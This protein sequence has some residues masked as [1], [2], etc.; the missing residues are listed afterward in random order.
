MRLLLGQRRLL[1]LPRGERLTALLE[2]SR[3]YQNEVSERLAEQVLHALY[4]LLRG[5]QAA[6]DA[7][8]GELLRHQLRERPNEVYHALL[9]VLLRLV[10]ILYAE[11]R[12]MLPEDETF[13]QHYSLA[14]LHKRLREDAA[15][16]P[17]TMDQ[18]F[19]AWAQLL[20][21]FRMIHDG[22]RSQEMHLPERRGVLF[23]PDRF[24]FLEGR[25]EGGARQIHERIHPPLV[26]DGTVYRVLEKLLVL[27]GERIS[28]RALDV[29][30]IGSVY[31]TMM[32][33]RLRPPTAAPGHQGLKR[34]GAPTTIDLEALLAEDPAKR[35]KWFS[36]HSDRKPTAAVTKEMKEASTL[37]E[38]H[39]AL[40]RVADHDAT[41]DPCPRSMV[42]QPS[43][44][45]AA[46]ALT[47]RALHR[48]H[49]EHHSGAYPRAPQGSER[50]AAAAGRHPRTQGLRP[51]HGFGRLLGRDL[52]PV[53]RHPHGVVGF[54]AEKPD[55]SPPK[56]KW[57]SPAV[58]SPSAVSTV[59][60]RTRS[61]STWPRCRSGW[62][63][64]PAN[65]PSPSSTTP[66][67]TETPWSVSARSR[68]R[69]ST[70]MP[71]ELGE[72]QAFVA[73]IREHTERSTE[74]RELIRQADDDTP[75]RN[76]RFSS[77]RQ[78]RSGPR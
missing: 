16:Y 30:Q 39:A 72:R 27:D 8:K 55:I 44:S 38:L 45:A 69:A 54:H 77:R 14:A 32:G 33:F 64:S 57:S 21:L 5:F 22:A 75:S 11:E 41:P 67:S 59:W 6:D 50:R 24:P 34:M 53:G 48:S 47:T 37:E 10:F 51:G 35:S 78:T 28:Y 71:E 31:E 68:S 20:T 26:P 52:L 40:D 60:I 49:R 19:G 7:G 42:L 61:R 17:D 3:R 29:E 70:G 36:D 15:L 4:E 9:T 2:D 58:S 46:Q 74:I 56:T 12:D 43:E 1:S 65:T 63:P 66:S 73:W 62:R 18:R 23:D 76:S 13:V 25:T